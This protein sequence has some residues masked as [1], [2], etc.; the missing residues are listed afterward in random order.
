MNIDTLKKQITEHRTPS[1]PIDYA[2]STGLDPEPDPK[3]ESLG[4][5]Y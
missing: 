2:E 4:S 5:I 3:F 1:L